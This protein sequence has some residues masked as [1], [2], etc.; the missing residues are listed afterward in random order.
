MISSLTSCIA[1]SKHAFSISDATHL[2]V[3]KPLQVAL[4]MADTKLVEPGDWEHASFIA[5]L[6]ACLVSAGAAITLA[7]TLEP[8]D[9]TT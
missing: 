6:Q 7:I 8:G 2:H 3:D 5:L 1:A 4:A 9:L